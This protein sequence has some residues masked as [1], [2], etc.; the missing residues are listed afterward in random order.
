MAKFKCFIFILIFIEFALSQQVSNDDDKP[1]LRIVAPQYI[2]DSKEKSNS[3]DSNKLTIGLQ[4]R[5][6]QRLRYEIQI[7]FTILDGFKN[8][9]HT[10]SIW[11]N[12]RELQKKFHIKN[13]SNEISLRNQIEIDALEL[14][15]QVIYTFKIIGYDEKN[16]TSEEQNF[17]ITYK[18]DKLEAVHS[19]VGDGVSLLLYGPETF[20]NDLEMLAVAD[21][22]FC[23]PVNDYYYKWEIKG[24]S[25]EDENDY[26]NIKG[27]YLMLPSSV[28][29]ADTFYE[30]SVTIYNNKSEAMASLSLP[31]KVFS[32]E[33]LIQNIPVA[34]SIGVNKEIPFVSSRYRSSIVKDAIYKWTCTDDCSYVFTNGSENSHIFASFSTEGNFEL[35]AEVTIMNKT[36]ESMTKVLI[37]SKIIPHVEVKY[38][39]QLPVNTMQKN[40]FVVTLMDLVPKC[41]AYW[42][43]ITNEEEFA[44]PKTDL[45]DLGTL[46]IK[47]YEEHF[48]QE[49]VDYDNNTLSKDITLTIPSDILYPNVKYK[50]RLNIA[51]PEPLLTESMSSV[52]RKNITTF[53]DIVFPSNAP[54]K[55]FPLEVSPIE[56][57]PMKDKFVFKTGAAKDDQS[58]YPLKYTFGYKIKN[59]TITIGSF[60]EYQVTQTQLPYSDDIETFY[61]VS[62]NNNASIYIVGPKIKANLKYN[63]TKDEINFKLSEIKGMLMRAEYSKTLNSAVTLILTQKKYAT[64]ENSE[65]YEKKIY[66]MLKTEID[67]LKS[68]KSTT[69]VYQQNIIEFVKMSKNLISVLSVYDETFI[70]NVLSLT[71]SVTRVKRMALSNGLRNRGIMTPDP[72]YIKNVL[73][74]S[75]LL[76]SSTNS[77]VA[78]RERRK[79]VEKIHLFVNSLCHILNLKSHTIESK[80]VIFEVS[81]IHSRQ[82]FIEPQKFS[83]ESTNIVYTPNSAFP[84]KFLC[85]AKIRYMLDMFDSSIKENENPVYETR[86]LDDNGN[87]EK[88]LLQSETI[89]EFAIMEIPLKFNSNEFTCSIWVEN[90]WNAKMCEKLKLNSTSRIACKCKTSKNSVIIKYEKVFQ[91]HSKETILITTASSNI[92]DKKV[93]ESTLK[94]NDLTTS[95]SLNQITTFASV[96]D[97]TTEK[98]DQV[99]KS[100]TEK[101][102]QVEKSTTT[103]NSNIQ[104]SITTTSISFLSTFSSSTNYRTTSSSSSSDD[105]KNNL[106]QSKSTTMSSSIITNENLITEIGNLPTAVAV[107]ESTLVSTIKKFENKDEIITKSQE[108]AMIAKTPDEKPHESNSAKASVTTIKTVISESIKKQNSSDNSKKK[109]NEKGVTKEKEKPSDKVP[110]TNK[111]PMSGNS[112]NTT[113]NEILAVNSASVNWIVVG[114]L[115]CLFFLI[116]LIL[117]LLHRCRRISENFINLPMRQPSKDIK[118]AKYH[119]EFIMRG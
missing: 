51:C 13:I 81:K 57:V 115:L 72:D 42:E 73:S 27:S 106:S 14:T 46:S 102:D 90:K 31:V 49:L 53:Y 105:K 86:I 70:E 33:F 60:Y 30:V 2:C 89:S 9:R 96:S 38:F 74:L 101:L 64:A 36:K 79:F 54:P 87:N 6:G 98:L 91:E 97:L 109:S 35:K 76:L 52:D 111:T 66:E 15:P 22:L 59:M 37:D 23:E 104:E 24:M 110:Q 114:S 88:V 92:D 7:D 85:I 112:M 56:G 41:T 103:E 5:E 4:T 26:L 3:S 83:N 16:R 117:I 80:F 40:E 69:Y 1:F 99:D 68:T 82:L 43:I 21:V 34:C 10:L 84:A 48:L 11:K 8:Q 77:E 50:F 100:T 55:A 118:Y 94:F 75:D 63:F 119:D 58:D 78:L 25:K 29:D 47:D 65:I 17:T 71:E 116:I 107:D 39:P 28:L 19:N 45:N 61:E 67:F 108:N 12:V 93:T 32:K 20:Y 44:N 113:D 95:S 18:G 62:D